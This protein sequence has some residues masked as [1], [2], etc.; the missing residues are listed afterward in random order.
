MTFNLLKQ[1]LKRSKWLA[2]VTMELVY[3]KVPWLGVRRG[4]IITAMCTIMHPIM[5][6]QNAIIF[7]KGNIIETV[8]KE[9][10]VN[11]AAAI[12]DLF[13][14]RFNPKAPLSDVELEKR[15]ENLKAMIDKDVEDT[16]AQELLMKMIGEFD[17]VKLSFQHAVCE[18]VM[19][20]MNNLHL[21]RYHQ[22]HI[23]DK[24]LHEQSLCIGSSS[25]PKNYVIERRDSS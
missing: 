24:H 20:I 16:T 6:K 7:S 13:L 1:E 11:H 3:E 25:R 4:E 17:I 19:L 9:R 5:S 21:F 15:S 2:P 23:E 22:V 14:A 10:Y 12:A 8:T 18:L